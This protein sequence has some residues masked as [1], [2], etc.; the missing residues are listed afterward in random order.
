MSSYHKLETALKVF[1]NPSLE[2]IDRNA[3]LED[4]C[5]YTLKKYPK[6]DADFWNLIESRDFDSLIKW[7]KD[8]KS[9]EAPDKTKLTHNLN[10]AKRKLD[11]DYLDFLLQHKTK[12][13]KSVGRTAAASANNGTEVIIELPAE[14]D[15]EVAVEMNIE[16]NQ[17]TS[18]KLKM[19]LHR[20]I[21]QRELQNG[22]NVKIDNNVAK[23]LFREGH[24]SLKS[25]ENIH[26]YKILRAFNKKYVKR[27]CGEEEES[28]SLGGT[29]VDID[30]EDI[31]KE[32]IDKEDKED[33]DKED[34]KFELE[35]EFKK[36]KKEEVNNSPSN[37]PLVVEKLVLIPRPNK[38]KNKREKLILQ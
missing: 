27:F 26:Y 20:Y 3:N 22:S 8:H 17:L 32:D 38:N 28:S 19:Y 25:G 21:A 1:L 30:K 37:S 24:C 4:H 34:K 15:R 9:T 5:Y 18:D 11:T 23:L 10:M 13:A 31:D 29:N 14:V 12:T 36:E 35:K 2:L 33:I 6:A 16:T 7:V